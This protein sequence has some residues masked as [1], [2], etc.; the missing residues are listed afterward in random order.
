VTVDR[1][2]ARSAQ[3]T[4]RE[5]AAIVQAAGAPLI[6]DIGRRIAAIE[7]R[8]GIAPPADQARVEAVAKQLIALHERIAA[9]EVAQGLRPAM[10]VRKAG[11]TTA[12]Q[13]RAIADDRAVRKQARSRW[14]GIL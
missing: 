5:T 6:A 13:L 1:R 10:P 2:G 9:Q 8:A 7:K 14:G 3:L 12:D 4:K 11:T